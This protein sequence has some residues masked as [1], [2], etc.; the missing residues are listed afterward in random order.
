MVTPHISQDPLSEESDVSHD[1][2]FLDNEDTSIEATRAS[3]RWVL[4]NSEGR[5]PKEAYKD[6]WLLNIGDEDSESDEMSSYNGSS[7]SRG[8]RE[9]R[10]S[11]D[12]STESKA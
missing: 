12:S 9:N 8:S 7:A 5:P 4:D 6:P 1:P 3:F 2:Q 10:N 11:A